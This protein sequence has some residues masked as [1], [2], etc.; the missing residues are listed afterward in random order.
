MTDYTDYQDAESPVVSGPAPAPEPENPL[1]PVSLVATLT[2]AEIDQQIAT[3]HQFPRSPA[4]ARD[5][6]IG[7]ATMDE[8]MAAEC[9]YSVPRGGRQIRG[10]SIRFAEIVMNS[11]GNLRCAARVSHE[12]RIERYVEAEAI[13]HDLESN[14][15]YV[16]RARRRIE[17]KK[18]RKSVDPD[19]IQIAGAAAISVARRNAILGCVPKPVWARALEAVESVI[20]G[21]AKTLTERRDAAIA[22][23]N[24][25]GVP[26]ERILKALEVAHLDDI[27]LDHLVDLNGMRAAL[28]TGEST[29][30]QLFPEEKTPGPRPESLTEKLEMLSKVDPE[31]GEIK[32]SGGPAKA[33]TS[34]DGAGAATEPPSS[35]APVSPTPEAAQTVVVPQ[36]AP[37]AAR[38]PEATQERLQA[39]GDA[40]AAKGM[41]GLDEWQDSL[42]SDELSSITV[43][44]D[45]AWREAAAKVSP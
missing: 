28:R 27:S 31:T 5:R 41:R 43:T 2:K 8:K 21:D 15:G 17:L 7:L 18:G 45:R 30:D 13:V 23:F 36:R 4:H 35:T 32:E 44:Q 22:Y 19:M 16:C 37:R 34:S 12:D 42:T 40:A 9:V 26:T 11:W 14:V 38:R 6:M 20:R 1:V 3:A 24:K 10:P 25:T 39:A 29:L 33:E